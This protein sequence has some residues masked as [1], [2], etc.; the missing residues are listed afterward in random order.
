MPAAPETHSFAFRSDFIREKTN[1]RVEDRWLI[2]P[3]T[4]ASLHRPANDVLLNK[5]ALRRGVLAWSDRS[6]P[7][8]ADGRGGPEPRGSAV[9]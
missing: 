6:G 5:I 3:N 7:R 4:S 1:C 8:V 9:R 2:A